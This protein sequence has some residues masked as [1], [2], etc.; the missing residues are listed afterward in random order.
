MMTLLVLILIVA[1]IGL[2]CLVA[3]IDQGMQRIT[4]AIAA[5][6]RAAESGRFTDAF[7]GARVPD[8]TM[9]AEAKMR[10]LRPDEPPAPPSPGG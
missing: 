4:R 1:V 7:V 2:G 6:P 3:V 5:L 9:M 10:A 8:L